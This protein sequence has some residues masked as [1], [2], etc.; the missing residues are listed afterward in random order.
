MLRH[1]SQTKPA[2]FDWQITVAFY[3]AL[4]L[5]NAH[6]AKSNNWNY[7][8]H[9]DLEHALNPYGNSASRLPESIYNAYKKLRNLS[10]TSRYLCDEKGNA[11]VRAFL[12]SQNDLLKAIGYLDAIC[13]FMDQHYHVKFDEAVRNLHFEKNPGKM[14]W[15]YFS[16]TEK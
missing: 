2:R 6:C 8:T 16:I 11:N 12:S 9:Y 5:M 14:P 4:H 15:R 3:T 7:P 13:G 10:R 1:L